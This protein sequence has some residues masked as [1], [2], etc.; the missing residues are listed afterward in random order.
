MSSTSTTFPAVDP[1]TREPFAEVVEMTAAQVDAVVRAA[2]DAQ[3]SSHEWR[4]PVNRAA[5]NNRLP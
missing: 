3:R 4:F 1:A 5:A 2:R